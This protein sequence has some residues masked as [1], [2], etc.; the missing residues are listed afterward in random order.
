MANKTRVQAEGWG[1]K[2]LRVT[3]PISIAEAM[4]LQKGDRL[5]WLFDR[6][7]LVVRKV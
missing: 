1:R 6:G 4:R 7:D 3:I 2:Q 5:E